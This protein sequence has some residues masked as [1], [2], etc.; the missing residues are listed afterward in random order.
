MKSP[1]FWTV[2]LLLLAT[3]VMLH[4]RGDVDR[5]PTS[6]PLSSMPQTIGPWSSRDIPM[7]D[8]VL[9]ILGKGDFLNRIYLGPR[10]VSGSNLQPVSTAS[11]PL[12]PISLFI[13]Y[14]ASQRSGQSIHSP[15]NCLPGAGWTFESSRYTDL[16]ADNGKVFRVGEYVISDGTTRQFVLYWYQAHGRSIANEYAAKWYMITDAIRLNR[17]DGAI[18]RVITPIQPREDVA[19]ARDRVVRF[20]GMMAPSLPRFIPD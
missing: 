4:S 20:T 12:V 18:V 15:Q 8:D 13:G 9:A 10:D 17:T 14:F 1:R 16:T 3:A 19:T 7:Q 11:A 5:V 2:A 6:Q